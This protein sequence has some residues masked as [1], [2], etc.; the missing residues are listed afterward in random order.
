M[1]KDA[2]LPWT[3]ILT[4]LGIAFA[5]YALGLIYSIER[6]AQ[7]RRQAL[8]LQQARIQ[9]IALRF[10]T[11]LALQAQVTQVAAVTV[12]DDPRS[13]AVERTLRRLLA[14]TDPSALSAIGVYYSGGAEPI[15]VERGTARAND[16][17]YA[18][19]AWYKAAIAAPGKP[20]FTDA[21]ATSTSSTFISA[22]ETFGSPLS[23]QGVVVV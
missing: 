11:D 15:R 4:I 9:Q 17:D 6:I 18:H 13:D 8:D 22:S 7:A 10:E 1:E 23:P 3:A 20:V 19:S 21:G 2:P 14:A 12:A 5:V 16:G